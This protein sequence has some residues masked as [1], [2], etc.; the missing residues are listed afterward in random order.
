MANEI[1]SRKDIIKVGAEK[2]GIGYKKM[3]DAMKAMLD[4]TVKGVSDGKDVHFVGFGTFGVKYRPARSQVK[5]GTTETFQLSDTVIP[6]FKPG[7]FF[8]EKVAA[9]NVLKKKYAS[10]YKPKT[11]KHVQSAA[12]PPVVK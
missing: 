11:P 6:R 3:R 12:Q 8:R 2:A 1:L 7:K 5:P 10:R 4:A 9:N